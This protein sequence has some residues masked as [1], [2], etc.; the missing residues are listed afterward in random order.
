MAAA[1]KADLTARLEATVEKE[2][3]PDVPEIVKRF[4]AGES[5]QVLG[6]ENGVTRRTIYNWMLAELGGEKYRELVTH[7]LVARIADADD[8][9]ER[10]NGPEEIAKRREIARFARMDFERRRPA[11]YGQKQEVN[12][13]AAAPTLNII[14]SGVGGHVVEGT[15]VPSPAALPAAQGD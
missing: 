6:K 8:G 10:A 7:M 15:V 11:L 5:A 13:N 4:L 14:L 2:G 12:H 1:A 9:L 3:P